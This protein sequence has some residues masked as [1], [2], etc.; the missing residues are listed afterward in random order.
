MAGAAANQSGL[1]PPSAYAPKTP[2]RQGELF[3][4]KGG[5]AAAQDPNSDALQKLALSAREKLRV[6]G[7]VACLGTSTP[8]LRLVAPLR[9][10]ALAYTT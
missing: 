10:S 5:A 7:Y 2:P 3:D 6:D 4:F 8:F 9:L 1:L